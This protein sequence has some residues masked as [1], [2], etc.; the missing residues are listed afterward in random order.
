MATNDGNPKST[1]CFFKPRQ[2]TEPSLT[3]ITAS[4][5]QAGQQAEQH[6]AAQL[7]E[8]LRK[9]GITSTWTNPNRPPKAPRP[10]AAQGETA[11]PLT[12]VKT[13]RAR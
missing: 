9:L 12:L 2:A 6:D 5:N 11:A 13:P 3:D 10:T 4:F 8:S 7:A 1:L